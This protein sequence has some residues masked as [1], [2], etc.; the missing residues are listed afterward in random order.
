MYNRY[1]SEY[2]TIN[3]CVHVTCTN[4]R[5]RK[6]YLATN[7]TTFTSLHPLINAAQV[8]MMTALGHY[9]GVLLCIFCAPNVSL[10][11]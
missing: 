7:W 1:I 11:P 10:R 4:I 2:M 3:G 6:S 9:L 5:E 8:K